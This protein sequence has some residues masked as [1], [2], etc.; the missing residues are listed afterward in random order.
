[1]L[2]VEDSGS[3]VP[4]VLLHGTP[5]DP[6][7]MR[8][9]AERL[10]SRHRVA[11]VH[12]PGY[13]R[14]GSATAETMEQSQRSLVDALRQ[15]GIDEAHVIGFSTGAY[16]AFFLA[17]RRLLRVR[18][19][20]G[21]GAVA[22][23]SHRSDELRMQAGLIRAGGLDLRK[24]CEDF[25]LSA[26]GLANGAWREHVR[27]WPDAIS[28]EHLA[29]EAEALAGAAD[30]LAELST[31]DLPVLLRVGTLDV[32]APPETSRQI[33]AR[34]PRCTLEVVPDAPHALLLEDFADTAVSIERFL[35]LSSA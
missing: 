8:P 11:L 27:A 16:R 4:V 15:R 31:I 9:L 17:A 28:S 13:G 5:V 7:H 33:A 19:I 26:R 12:L 24:Y 35:A 2:H 18:S 10:A 30:M 3:G 1:M 23:F 34:L 22:S 25:G 14:S 21:L 20:V 32:G 6:G 29:Q